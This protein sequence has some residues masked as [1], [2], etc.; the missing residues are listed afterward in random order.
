[1]VT[2]KCYVI[3]DT[4]VIEKRQC[5]SCRL[6][7]LLI[8]RFVLEFHFGIHGIS[9]S[10]QSF[11]HCFTGPNHRLEDGYWDC[12]YYCTYG[13]LKDDRSILK[14]DKDETNSN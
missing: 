6:S 1:M 7:P 10:E 11:A 14:L 12:S 13:T 5:Q 8:L 3:V 4:M 2:C 9:Q